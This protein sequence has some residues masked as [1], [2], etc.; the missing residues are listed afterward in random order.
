M[1]FFSHVKYDKP[2]PDG[3]NVELITNDLEFGHLFYEISSDG[4]LLDRNDDGTFTDVNYTGSLHV[5]SHGGEYRDYIM[6]F[7]E[8]GN[9][10]EVICASDYMLYGRS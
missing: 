5:Y 9:L 7:D 10:M 1:S 4:R 6:S 3:A 2:L 8:D